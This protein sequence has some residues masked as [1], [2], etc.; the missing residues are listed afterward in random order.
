ML[1]PALAMV[2]ICNFVAVAVKGRRKIAGDG[3]DVA[4]GAVAVQVDVGISISAAHASIC[5]KKINVGH[6][7]IA[8]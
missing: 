7:L 2:H 8:A 1:S 4:G 6:K 5:A 3:V